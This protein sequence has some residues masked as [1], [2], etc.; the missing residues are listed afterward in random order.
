[1]ARFRHFTE[2]GA[3]QA[4]A[5]VNTPGPSNIPRAKERV[6]GHRRP[7][8]SREE[9]AM[10]KARRERLRAQR[11]RSHVYVGNLSPSV[12]EEDIEK[13]FQS[14]GPVGRVSIRRTSHY[15]DEDVPSDSDASGRSSRYAT[16]EFNHP[17]SSR[18][19]IQRTGTELDGCRIM[20]CLTATDLPEVQR[21]RERHL[22]LRENGGNIF[23]TGIPLQPTL[24]LKSPDSYTTQGNAENYGLD[25]RVALDPALISSSNKVRHHLVK[26]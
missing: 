10:K 21:M 17:H 22:E 23:K 15:I 9:L 6:G 16:V 2:H 1:M 5:N 4:H 7:L 11:N 18:I 12:S 25:G 19:A 13:V 14:S 3:R 8:P 26:K 24:I 20:V